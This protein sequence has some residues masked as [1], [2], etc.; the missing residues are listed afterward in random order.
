[1]HVVQ[2]D[3]ATVFGIVTAATNPTFVIGFEFMVV[4]GTPDTF[5][6]LFN[7][8]TPGVCYGSYPSSPFPLT[9]GDITMTPGK[10][11]RS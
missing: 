7:P 3:I 5:K 9:T 11:I 1:M 10:K 2:H 8:Y 6:F 4:D